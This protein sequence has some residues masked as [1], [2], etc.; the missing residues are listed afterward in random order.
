MRNLFRTTPKI[1][2]KLATQKLLQWMTIMEIDNLLTAFKIQYGNWTYPDGTRMARCST[3]V[4]IVFL[5]QWAVASGIA[6]S[7]AAGNPSYRRQIEDCYERLKADIQDLF[8]GLNNGVS[9]GP[10]TVVPTA[11]ISSDGNAVSAYKFFMLNYADRFDEYSNAFASGMPR[12]FDK[13]LTS[14]IDKA[15]QTIVFVSDQ[16]KLEAERGDVYE[17]IR[18]GMKR[19]LQ[20]E[21]EKTVD[22]IDG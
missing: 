13:S 16:P 14:V 7:K 21:I 8:A 5:S 3:K 4:E 15:M 6:S 9:V 19:F 22:L 2:E 10:N 12:S 11:W 17:V 18:D 20:A 1:A